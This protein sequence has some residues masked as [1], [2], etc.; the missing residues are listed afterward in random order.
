ME[1][2]EVR[3]PI[4]SWTRSLLATASVCTLAVGC[5]SAML[6]TPIHESAQ[7]AVY[8]Q[9][10]YDWSFAAA[11]PVSFDPV[12]IEKILRGVQIDE[13]ENLAQKV[14]M[15]VSKG[16]RVFSDEDAAFL[17]PQLAVALSRASPEQIVRFQVAQT[18]VTESEP[19]AGTLYAEKFSLYL[20][21]TQYQGKTWTS[22]LPSLF[23]DLR[24]DS[25]TMGSAA[26]K[27]VPEGVARVQKA[28]ESASLGQSNL[29]SLVID[30]DLLAKQTPTQ[31]KM[32]FLIMKLEEL[33]QSKEMLSKKDSELKALRQDIDFLRSQLAKREAEIKTRKAAKAPAKTDKKKSAPVTQR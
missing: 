8:L 14:S 10:A 3:S 31:T 24:S 2:Y 11:H 16:N 1:A 15:A 5:A 23:S 21:L 13:S 18:T 29:T 28:T 19:T 17:A 22:G 9:E 26:V 4:S 6:T 33:R 12:T 32:E 27:F 25:E 7:G 30:K 20:T